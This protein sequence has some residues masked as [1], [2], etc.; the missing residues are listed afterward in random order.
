MKKLLVLPLLALLFNTAL[1]QS[2][3]DSAYIRDHYTKIEKYIPMRD[4]VK[5]FASIYL[6]KDQS[7]KY[8]VLMTRSPY[9]AAPYGEKEFKRT[10]GQNMLLAKE[11]FIF[12]YEDVRG[13][14]MSEGKFV[15]VRPERPAQSDRCRSRHR[16]LRHHRLADQK[17]A[18]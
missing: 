12:V 9:S 18:Q 13:R 14:W 7:Q 8:P 6:P 10:L 3:A 11:G 16:H 2:S 15:D 17:P 4:G 1:A 5:L